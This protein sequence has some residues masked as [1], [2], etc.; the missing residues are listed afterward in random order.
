MVSLM[1]IKWMELQNVCV[2]EVPGPVG[3][4]SYRDHSIMC[5]TI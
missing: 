3:V 5:I 4:L 1:V 2:L